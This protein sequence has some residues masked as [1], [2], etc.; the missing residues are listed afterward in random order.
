MS[1]QALEWPKEGNSRVPYRVFADPDI[2][3]AELDRIFLGASWQYLALAAEL[4]EPGDYKTTFLGETPV[5]VTRGEDGEIHAMVNRCAHRGNLVCLKP[6]GHTNDGLTRVYHVWRS[7]VADPAQPLEALTR[8]RQGYL[9][10]Q[11]AAHLLHNFPHQPP[12]LEGRR[13]DRRVRRASRQLHLWRTARRQRHLRP[14][15]FRDPFAARG[16]QA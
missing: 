5:I 9:S 3:Q 14:A 10:R 13:R 12:D 16:L 15:L 2:Y 1:I 8:K 4:P 11:P 6:R 7:L